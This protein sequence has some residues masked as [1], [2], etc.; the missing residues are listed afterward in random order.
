[1][2]TIANGLHHSGSLQDA[3]TKGWDCVLLSDACGTT[4]PN[5]ARECI[6]FNCAKTWGFV[7]DVAALRSGVES[8]TGRN[9]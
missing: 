3:Y 5:Y 9:L 6:E 8:M 4:S 1:M 2:Q 7:T